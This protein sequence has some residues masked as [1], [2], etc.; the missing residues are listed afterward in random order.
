MDMMSVLWQVGIFASVL[1]FGVKMF[2]YAR[3]LHPTN[4]W[5][6]GGFLS[7][8]KSQ[9]PMRQKN[10]RPHFCNQRCGLPSSVLNR[11]IS[12]FLSLRLLRMWL[13]SMP[14]L[15]RLFHLQLLLMFLPL[16]PLQLPLLSMN[17]PPI[18]RL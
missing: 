4:L 12:M 11:I 6:V 2:P 17:L 8:R 7:H 18:P 14:L 13:L 15:L 5:F 16:R 3:V 1:V 10:S 9:F